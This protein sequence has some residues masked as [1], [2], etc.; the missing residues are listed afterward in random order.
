MAVDG[1]GVPVVDPLLQER[2]A[3]LIGVFHDHRHEA[4]ASFHQT[5][6]HQ[7]SLS[8]AVATVT[9]SNRIWLIRQIERLTGAIAGDH[10]NSSLLIAVHRRHQFRCIDLSLDPIQSTE[11]FHPIIKP[12]SDLRYRGNVWNREIRGCRIPFNVK[13]Q[14]GAAKIRRSLSK[15]V[16]DPSPWVQ[17]DLIWQAVVSIFAALGDDGASG[18]CV[19][20]RINRGRWNAASHHPFVATPM[21]GKRMGDRTDDV[22][23]VGNRRM[24]GHQFADVEARYLCRN[25]VK[26]PT[27]FYRGLGLHVVHVHVW[28]TTWKPYENDVRI[29]INRHPLF[30]RIRSQAKEIRQT[31]AADSK[32]SDGKH[33]PAG[34]RARTESFLGTHGRLP[35]FKVGW[36]RR[37]EPDSTDT[38]PSYRAIVK[39]SPTVACFSAVSA[40]LN[41]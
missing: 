20:D 40:P 34:H 19:V 31:H 41:S 17:R 33:F 21:V 18:W 4:D 3:G 39:F 8:P 15:Y 30:C 26:S 27:I 38:L 32:C 25:R 29:G 12:L 6:G 10:P 24:S 1:V 36:R 7:G 9:I 5:A 11:Q 35:S 23:L 16:I 2:D 14:I 37:V 13:R 28:R 22:V